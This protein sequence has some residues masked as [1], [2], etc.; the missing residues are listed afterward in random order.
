[1]TGIDTQP[2]NMTKS[3]RQ[4]AQK[5]EI[6]AE[7][8]AFYEK[9]SPV[10]AGKKYP[11]PPPS[12]CPDCRAQRRLSFRNERKLY[13]RKCD[14][15]G[16]QILSMYSP[17]K[18]Y[19]VYD[20]KEWWSDKWDALSYGKNYDP[21][22]SFFEQFHELW[23]AVPQ[24]NVRGE[25]NLNSDYCNLTA[26]CKN[27]YLVFES[28]NNEDCLYGYW[29]QKCND[30]AD[31]CFSHESTLCYEC[32]DCYNCYNLLHSR[33]CNNCSDSAFLID[34]TG[35][36]N[37]LFCVN[38]H[39]KEYCVFNKQLTKEEYEKE[40]KK[41]LDGSS[42]TSQKN[43]KKFEEFALKYPRKYAHSFNAE[44]CT[45]DYIRQSKNCVNCFHAHDAEDCK[46][47]EHVWRVSKNNMDVS[48]V[49]RG[50]EL[51]YESINTAIGATHDLFCIQCWSGTADLIYCVS[52]FA[53]QNCF[54][55]VGL[56][57]EKYCILNTQY[58][59][60]EYEK[61]VPKI[62][63]QME[64]TSAQREDEAARP[65]EG[66][67]G[68]VGPKATAIKEWGEFFPPG[69]SEF[70]YNETVAQEQFP[71]S[72]DEALKLGFRWSDAEPAARYE[73]G[74]P[75]LPDNIS[76]IKD[77]ILKQILTCETCGK[78]YKIIRQE[79]EFYRKL[80]LPAPRTCPDCR[81]AARMSHRNPNK[82]YSRACAKCK[83]P[84]QTTYA[85]D[86]P[87]KVYCEKCYLKAVY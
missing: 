84:I 77:E 30:C 51:V 69:L 66:A 21:T 48:T 78:N 70:G 75:D 79:L 83:A 42:E 27:C 43:I 73:G 1:M 34:C 39:Q 16:R 74:K 7:D 47:G 59:K 5:F 2:R 19:K 10:F 76:D 86:R 33:D 4:C 29:L 68:L 54:G 37:C 87:E 44:N 9:V 65:S 18:P 63:A 8:L 36:K 64:K 32:D 56:R 62:I 61:L 53:S 28:S 46:Y 58:S 45:G 55:C 80:K 49:G 50:A 85:P 25:N 40:K 52:C 41:Y 26:N 17:D 11:M 20:H 12:L 3:C 67:L 23:L 14:L 81:H 71:L 38:L 35:C 24:M 82:L 31:T 22:R 60:E 13:N 15:S 72:Q 57:H 6:T